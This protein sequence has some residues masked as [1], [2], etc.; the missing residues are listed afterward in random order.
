MEAAVVG[1]KGPLAVFVHGW[2]DT[3]RVWDPVV[4]SMKETHRCI[5]VTLPQSHFIAGTAP[6]GPTFATL[7]RFLDELVERYRK[8]DERFVLVSHDWGCAVA[9]RYE[10]RHPERVERMVSLDVG[11]PAE[12]APPRLGLLTLAIMLVYQSVLIVALLLWHYVPVVGKTVGNALAFAIAWLF[13]APRARSPNGDPV[14]AAQCYF[15]LRF[16]QE[17]LSGQAPKAD[18]YPLCPMLF[19]YGR[20]KAGTRF[21]S[22]MLERH[23]NSVKDGSRW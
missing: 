10:R 13:R 19:V 6:M 1:T 5:V 3:G 23:L 15:Y 9:H 2:P 17:F 14:C 8:Q 18:R 4:A 7:D 22:E 21:H 16:W 11:S 12:I 20:R